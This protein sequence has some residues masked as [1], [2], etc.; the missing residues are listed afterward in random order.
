MM[1]RIKYGEKIELTDMHGQKR[2]YV[3]AFP[4]LLDIP[5]EEKINEMIKHAESKTKTKQIIVCPKKNCKNNKKT[6]FR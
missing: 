3:C 1:D 6:S 4:D 2:E 5:T